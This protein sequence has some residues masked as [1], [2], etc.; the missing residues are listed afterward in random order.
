[1]RDLDVLADLGVVQIRPQLAG[2][3]DRHADARRE[4][5]VT[6]AAIEQPGQLAARRT[7]SAGQADARKER[8]PRRADAGVD[9]AQLI[10]GLKNIRALLK[11]IGGQPDRQRCQLGTFE[12]VTRWQLGRQ[13][14]PQQQRQRIAVLRYQASVLLDVHPR[15]VDGA[16]RLTQLQ[17]RSDPDVET[18]LG[19]TKTLFI[20]LER[21]ASDLQQSLIGLQRQ[22][23]IGDTGDQTDLGA[24]LCGLAGEE[25]FQRL[26]AQTAQ[27][28]EQVQLPGHAEG[29]A[30]LAADGRLAT[31]VQIARSA[32]ARPRTVGTHRR[33]QIGTLDAVQRAIGVDIQR[34]HAQVAVVLQRYLDQLL[35][36][37]VAKEFAPAQFA[38]RLRRARGIG[39]PFGPGLGGRTLRPLVVGYQRAAAQGRQQCQAQ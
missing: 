5:P 22:P 25:L 10:L 8:R 30:V 27:T 35:Q 16:A 18:A 24:A 34:R 32:A 26:V 11:Q 17:R 14:L 33:Q 31:H 3:E 1:M 6:G 19:Q 2:I 38:L 13:A 15:T 7:R 28:T 9:R 20:G 39:R 12:T 29:G 36:R 37:R 4:A 23:G 21:I